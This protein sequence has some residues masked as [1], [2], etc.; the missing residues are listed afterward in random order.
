MLRQRF[1][2][3]CSS[4]LL[5]V[6]AA[7]GQETLTNEGIVNLVKS[8]MSEDLI[9]NVIGKQ[10]A[11]F[12]LG[13]NDLVTLKNAGVSERI[14]TA[15][16]NKASGLAVG[17]PAA[18]GAAPSSSAGMRTTPTEPGIYYKK[19]N[20]YFELLSEDV[21]WKTGGAMK[22]I[23]SAGI[24]KKD[25]KGSLTG[26]SSRNFLQNPIE[27]VISPPTGL[28][29]NDY[30]LLPMTPAKGLRGFEVGPK[31]QQSGVAKGAIP[32]GVEKVGPNA[33]R[34]VFQTA[35]GP[36]EYGILTAKSVGGVSGS[37]SRMFTFRLLI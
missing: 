22:S 21:L 33:F 19:N 20:E 36:G 11:S 10:P 25:L 35:L 27:I 15:M 12:A 16:V 1:L 8:G 26:P 17:A 6:A 29:I 5:L 13:A 14:L 24:V 7:L 18:P 37:A 32:F 2:L 23:A 28:T 30:I 3:F 9:M 4:S 31:N 34:M